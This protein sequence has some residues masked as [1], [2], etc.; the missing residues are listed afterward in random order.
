M[1]YMMDKVEQE[2]RARYKA[3]SFD[4]FIAYAM[5]KISHADIGL[6]RTEMMEKEAEERRARLS[7]K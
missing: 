2:L 4:D 5:E 3:L 1:S 7:I 6:L